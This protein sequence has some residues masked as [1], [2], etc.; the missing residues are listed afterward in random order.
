MSEQGSQKVQQI[1]D[2]YL[3]DLPEEIRPFA[4]SLV[5]SR[6]AAHYE[7]PHDSRVSAT[8]IK[9]SKHIEQELQNENKLEVLDRAVSLVTLP[10]HEDEQTEWYYRWLKGNGL[11]ILQD[12]RMTGALN[13]LVDNPEKS[14]PF[15]E[16]LSSILSTDVKGLSLKDMSNVPESYSLFVAFLVCESLENGYVTK[17]RMDLINKA[18]RRLMEPEVDRVMRFFGEI[19]DTKELYARFATYRDETRFSRM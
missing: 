2:K 15:M 8:W 18:G 6:L 9:N 16:A 19:K 1:Y 5:V 13:G 7:S 17:T 11:S 4:S 14:K 3:K 10:K 12:E